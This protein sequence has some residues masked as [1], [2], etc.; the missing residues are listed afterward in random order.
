M[1]LTALRSQLATLACTLG[2]A[3]IP[4]IPAAS[5]N[6]QL[7]EIGA[8]SSGLLSPAEEER[9]GKAFMRSLRR[10][11]SIVSDPEMADY[12]HNLGARL[13][14]A[15]DARGREFR[16]FLVDDPNI[17]AFAGPAGYIGI[18]TGLILAT[19]SESEL[20]AVVAHEIAH[21][22]QHHLL[23]RFEAATQMNLPTTALVLAGLV[24]GAASGSDDVA[25]A[26]VAGVQA[27]AAQM[28]INF[29]RANEQEADRVGI[30]ILAETGFDPHSMPGFFGRMERAT[31]LYASNVPEF[32]RTHPV[33]T[34]RI[35][36]SMTR[37]DSYPYRQYPDNIRYHLLRARLRA[38]AANNPN[39]A[40]QGFR[41]TIQDGRY[42]NEAAEHYGLALA[43]MRTK[44]YAAARNTFRRSRTECHGAQ[45]LRR[46]QAGIEPAYQG[47][48]RGSPPREEAPGR[49]AGGRPRT[50]EEET[51]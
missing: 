15:R 41:Q 5:E 39:E 9:I 17:N 49:W 4:N 25:Q 46:E 37:A 40:V 19:Q 31:R 8:S 7:P 48:T 34:S 23:R 28:Q 45:F 18:N 33:S 6:Y 42:R 21:V 26:A 16:F 14:S 47:R 27:G 43:L 11:L 50:T 38:R 44:D 20:A 2:L 32:L 22:T 10:H 30:G 35:A 24:L 29:T 36:D 12:I 13:T 3:V 1:R 51:P